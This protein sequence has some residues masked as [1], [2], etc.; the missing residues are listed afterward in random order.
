[1]CIVLYC[2]VQYVEIYTKQRAFT[3]S[4]NFFSFYLMKNCW[5]MLVASR[6]LWWPCSSVRYVWTLV[7]AV[8]KWRIWCCRQETWKTAKKKNII[9]L[10]RCLILKVTNNNYQIWTVCGFKNSEN[11]TK[12]AT[13]S[14]FFKIMLH[15][16]QQNQFEALW[17][18]LA[19]KFYPLDLTHQ[20]WLLQITICLHQWIAHLLSNTLVCTKIWKMTQW[21]VRSKRGRFLLVWHS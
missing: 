17:R 20:A 2:C 7:M 4:I 21:M 11:T 14:V 3:D 8:Q 18:H 10:G 12:E 6:S 16:T 9:S 19:G 13:E 15:H 5:I 1:M